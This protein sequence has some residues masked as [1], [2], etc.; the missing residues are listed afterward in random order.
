MDLGLTGKKVAITGGSRGIGRAIAAQM[1][2]EGASVSICARGQEGVDEAVAALGENVIGEAVD[3][4][5]G[6][7]LRGWIERSAEQMGGLDVFVMNASGGGGGTDDKR[8]DQNY[9]VDLMGLVRGSQAA[10]EHLAASG[11]GAILMIAT[12]AALE[13][14][15]P[16]PSSYMSLKAGAI[17]Y[18]AGLAQTLAPKGI[19]VNTISPGPIF[20][21]NGPWDQIKSAMPE[22]YEANAA[23]HPT[24]RMGTP[25][26][27]ANVAAF[28]CSPAASWVTGT[29]IVVDGGFTKR[30]NF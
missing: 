30:I 14:F 23:G 12:T 9:Q 10:E 28:L 22:F 27:V 19:R 24:G 18:A 29:N 4:G 5:D 1:L 17:A 13:H 25:E 2:A 20:F 15:G 3:V 16:G 6:D 11:E 7:A 26:E 21:E 8:F